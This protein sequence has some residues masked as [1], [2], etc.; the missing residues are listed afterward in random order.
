MLCGKKWYYRKREDYD[1][2]NA[3]KLSP[4]TATAFARRA[5]FASVKA[6]GL[7]GG[8]R[9]DDRT[10]TDATRTSF[11]AYNLAGFELMTNFL[12]IRHETTFGLNVGVRDII[13]T[14]GTFSAYIAN[15]RHC[16]LLMY[17]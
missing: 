13:A 1:G 10:I 17:S 12:Q 6:L 2:R 14:L 16:D 4:M 5:K 15:L 7:F 9:L 3:K 11:D 8:H